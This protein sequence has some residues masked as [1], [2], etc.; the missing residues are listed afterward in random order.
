MV[1]W[2][3]IAD[4]FAHAALREPFG[5]VF[6]EALACGTPVVSSRRG[7]L[8]EIV[9]HGVEGYLAR[10]VEGACTGVEGL[11]EPTNLHRPGGYNRPRE[12]THWRR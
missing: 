6:I 4:V 7:A 10:D 1:G 11:L 8:P 5:I 12:A 9:R 3:Q 2:C